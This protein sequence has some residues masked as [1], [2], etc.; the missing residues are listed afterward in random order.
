MGKQFKVISSTPTFVLTWRRHGNQ[1]WYT[2]EVRPSWLDRNTTD[3]IRNHFDPSRKLAARSAWSYN[4]TDRKQAEQL[5]TMAL[6]RW[7]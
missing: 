3:A 4:Y 6:L 1:R 7:S 5:Y 2:I